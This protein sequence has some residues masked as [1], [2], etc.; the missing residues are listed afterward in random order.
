MK[1]VFMDKF[2][3]FI[4]VKK[5][6]NK[7]DAILVGV[8]GGVDSMALIYALYKVKNIFSFQLAVAHINYCLRG[9][10]SDKD[11]K[12]VESFCDKY[13]VPFFL[14]KV[15]LN[16]KENK[17]SLQMKARDVRYSFFDNIS[18]KEGFNK[19]AIAH[20]ADDNA[21]TILL[22]IFRGTGIDGLKGIPIVRDNIIRPLISF[23]RGE[24]VQFCKFNQV[25]FRHDKSN[26]K[27][28]Y[29]RNFVRLRLIPKIESKINVALIQNV[30]QLSSIFSDFSDFIN[31]YVKIA[32]NHVLSKQRPNLFS[33]DIEKLNSYI[34]YIK[35]KIVINCCYSIFNIALAF[36]KVKKI[37]QLI[38]AQSGK[39][40]LIN[41]NITVWKEHNFL[42][43]NKLEE[44]TVSSVDVSLCG[45]TKFYAGVISVTEV[46]DF[47]ANLD[48]NVEFIDKEKI[49]GEL[50]V[51][52][53]VDGDF[54]YPIGLNR[55]KKISDLLTDAKVSSFKKKSV[56]VI[57]NN[58][59]IVWVIGYRLDERFK[60]TNQTKKILKVEFKKEI[61][62][63]IN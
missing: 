37:L 35:E 42:V 53:W 32:E 49:T 51:R 41:N 8:S 57:E 18:E 34:S 3:E 26:F 2:I 40:L 54:F 6:I 38:D 48:P 27:V 58:G 9:D 7:G 31:E 1:N 36:G 14:H 21:E 25:K 47:K 44:K 19:I 39:R 23:R 63:G 24:I 56:F 29:N 59:I 52:K 20:N 4:S 16:K 55:R 45:E 33:L 30:N 61:N 22:N 28:D 15:K 11:Q 43:F 17:G 62:F 50:K 12:L 5:L 13:K 60:C 10:D 46:R